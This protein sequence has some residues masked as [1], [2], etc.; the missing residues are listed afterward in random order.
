MASRALPFPQPLLLGLLLGLLFPVSQPEVKTAGGNTFV[1]PPYLD[2]VV[3]DI[4]GEGR[5]GG[6]EICP[7][8]P[9]ARPLIA[10]PE[11]MEEIW[12]GESILTI[13]LHRPAPGRW[14]FRT[15]RPARVKILSQRFFPRGIL[16]EPAGETPLRQ[17]DRISVAYRLLEEDGF[18]LREIVGYPL[19]ADMTLI[20]PDGHQVRFAMER[21]PDLGDGVFRTR[22]LARCDLSG[23]YW[24]EVVVTTRDLDGRKVTIFQDRW[25][26]FS[27]ETLPRRH[28][29]SKPVSF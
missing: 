28:K 16:L 23:R 25:S 14:T 13:V 4:L 8:D 29:S 19:S 3:F 10:G 2:A 6:V 21:Q 7:P 5:T 17:N 26:G 27:V 12:L 22:G 15:G 1:V 18:P 24:T 9:I 11:G 20:K